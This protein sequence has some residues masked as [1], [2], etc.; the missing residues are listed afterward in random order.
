VKC[1]GKQ[2]EAKHDFH[3]DLEKISDISVCQAVLNVPDIWDVAAR[4][5]K[6][7]VPGQKPA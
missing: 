7:H 3:K 2:L 5:S 4:I 1:A 6:R